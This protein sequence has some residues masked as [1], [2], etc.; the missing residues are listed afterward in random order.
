MAY[1]TLCERFIGEPAQEPSAFGCA[2]PLGMQ[3]RR[4]PSRSYTRFRHNAF[5]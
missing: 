1:A 3:T 5:L 2:V 4:A